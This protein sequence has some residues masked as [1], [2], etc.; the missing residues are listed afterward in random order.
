MVAIFIFKKANCSLYQI[1]RTRRILLLGLVTMTAAE[2]R[3]TLLL[4]PGVVFGAVYS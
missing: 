2:T 4:S 3:Q 1:K